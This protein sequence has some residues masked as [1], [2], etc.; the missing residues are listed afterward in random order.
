MDLVVPLRTEVDAIAPDGL[1]VRLL[2]ATGAASMAHFT[3][4]P[5]AVGRAVAH[6]TVDEAWFFVAGEGKMWL[7]ND[8][9]ETVVSV[10]AGTS[11]AL[12]LGTRFQVRNGGSEPLTIVG[13]TVP[14]WPGEQEAIVV[15]G[16]WVPTIEGA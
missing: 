8:D 1:E 15:D 3:V 7:A 16:A 14:P 11:V 9:G 2:A 4:P 12:P 13:V 6:R 5:F 10:T